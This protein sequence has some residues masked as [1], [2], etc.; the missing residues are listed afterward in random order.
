ML[1]KPVETEVRTPTDTWSGL[2]FSKSMPAEAVK[3]MRCVNRRSYKS[4]L[5]NNLQEWSLQESLSKES[6]ASGS[7][8]ENWRERRDSAS[9]SS[10]LSSSSASSFPVFASSSSRSRADK[11][12][13]SFL[14]SSNYFDSISSLTCSSNCCSSP[15]HKQTA[16]L[17][18]LFSQLG[19]GKY[20]DIFQQQEI[21]FQTFLTLTDEDLKEVGISTFGAR[22][23]MLLAISDFSKS[24]KKLL[25]PPTVRPG[26]L[27]GGASGRLPRIVDVDIAAQSNRW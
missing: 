5:G 14:S 25:D 13:E 23:K 15:T 1:K 27:E 16:D 12:S 8:S 18:E 6:L 3:E 19:L 26:Y 7:D 20:I 4:Y 11:S 2:G 9:S 21:D 17:P 10:P 24:K 22:R